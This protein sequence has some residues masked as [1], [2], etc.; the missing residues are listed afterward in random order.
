MAIL[1]VDDSQD[2]CL[3]IGAYLR[4]ADYA[5]V[6]T[7]S[8]KEALHY[9]KG[10]TEGEPLA[11]IDLILLDV[12]MPGYDGLDA[13]TRIKSMKQFEAVPILMVSA[14]TTSGTIQL[15]FRRGAVDYIRKPIIKP[16]LLAKVAMVLRIQ[17]DTNQRA[18]SQKMIPQKAN[19][20]VPLTIDI[21]T[22]IM[23]WWSFDELFE[24]EWGRAAK[25]HLPISLLFFTLENFKAFNDTY[26]YLTGDECLQKI[27]HITQ[28]TFAQPGQVV[29]RYR[30][31][32]FVVL[33]FGT[34]AEDAKSMTDHLHKTI[35]AL[36]VGPTVAVGVATA[37]PNEG[38]SRGV[39]LTSAKN[40]VP[41]RK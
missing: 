20:Q 28:E 16:E 30:G 8:A 1:L 19:I 22:G 13:C 34:G 6:P 37:Y 29:A 5:V 17:D 27:A 33:L 36:D 31:A 7:N 25:E 4:S 3:L 40:A 12:R 11:P 23:N 38:T 10:L 32:E 39:L 15:A 35:E 14:D 18:Q 26:G 2:D 9:L 41:N 21:L 24:Q